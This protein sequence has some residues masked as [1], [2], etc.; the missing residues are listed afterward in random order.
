MTQETLG[1]DAQSMIAPEGSNSRKVFIKTY[2][3]QM[4]VYDSVR[5]S[6]ALAK[7]GYVQTEDMGEADLVLLNTCHIR[8]KAAEKVYSALG[9]L[10]DMKKSR[11][12][13]GREFMIG[14]AG[15]VAQAE[16]EEIL[17]RAPA[18]DV[19]IGP[20]TYHRLP[21]ALKR[22]RSGERV[23]ETEYAVEDKFEHLPVAEKATLRTRGVTA[24]LTVQEGCDKFC[25][26]CVVP[27]TRGSE[28]SRPVR[29][30]VDE[31]MK[32][33]DAGVRE[34]TLLG[35]NVNAWQGEGPKGEKWGLAELLY[36]LAEIP[37]LARL[38]YTTSHPRDMDDRLIGAHRD[39]RI[40]MPYLHL[41][42]QSGSDRI[43]KAMNRRHTGEEYIQLIEKIRAAR[44]DIAMSGDFIVGFPGETDRDFEDTM[45]MVET[46]KYAQAFSFKYS[47]RPG[48][49][50]ADLT[51]QVAEEVKA[52]RLERLQ[53]LLLRQQKEFAESLVGKTMD[54]LLEKPGRMHEQLIG[55]SPWLQSVNLDAK[56]LKIGDI[57][58]VR[59]TATGPNSLFAE[60][61]GS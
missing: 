24:F 53:A 37:G 32:L 45:A 60:V 34:I 2:G 8:E 49:P 10:R 25:T 13:Q 51:D 40:L 3:C 18:V 36:R 5:M 23:I 21:D 12:E 29:Q 41:P 30:I 17:R 6:D 43:L 7:D 50:G 44:P 52:E 58:N 38:R 35:Q 31:A 59:I 4:N 33:V 39:L 14:V 15:C 27:Y 47:T 57:V 28:V 61:A 42:V 20:Q 26:F 1:L 11:E 19:V 48:T 54:V 9:R 46:V 56:T 55:R 22:V 16:G